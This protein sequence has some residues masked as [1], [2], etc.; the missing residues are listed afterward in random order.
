MHGGMERAKALLIA[1]IEEVTPRLKPRYLSSH[2]QQ[3]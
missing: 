2:E 1:A 3:G